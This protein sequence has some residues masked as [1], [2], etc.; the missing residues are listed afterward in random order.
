MKNIY[1]N[2]NLTLCYVHYFDDILVLII[3]G[4]FVFSAII[5]YK[6]YKYDSLMKKKNPDYYDNH[7]FRYRGLY[8][9]QP[10]DNNT[11][12]AE[13]RSIIN[14]YNYWARLFW[15]SVIISFLVVLY[16]YSVN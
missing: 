11:T 14:N 4:L 9:P 16:L 13:L 3:L 1:D 12:D 10:I 8:L 7:Y 5:A 2:V 15:I 6:G